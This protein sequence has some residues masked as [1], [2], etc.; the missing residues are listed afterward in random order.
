MTFDID[1]YIRLGLYPVSM[2]VLHI[3]MV[4]GWY[5]D[6][7]LMLEVDDISDTEQTLYLNGDP[8]VGTVRQGFKNGSVYT[9]RFFAGP[10]TLDTVLGDVPHY[11]DA[12]IGIVIEEICRLSG[13][14]LDLTKSDSGALETLL[15][16]YMPLT[17][18][19]TQQ[20]LTTVCDLVPTTWFIDF[21]GNLVIG[22]RAAQTLPDA[23]EIRRDGRL[24]FYEVSVQDYTFEP[25][26][27]YEDSSIEHIMHKVDQHEAC[28]WLMI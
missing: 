20:H 12:T 1:P 11:Q 28:T 8:F 23:L 4:G 21:A 17:T 9:C 27:L 3:P 25:G 15:K 26:V 10:G 5:A 2:C 18:Q 6:I 22:P 13:F 19:T 7:E 24:G 16:H 14:E